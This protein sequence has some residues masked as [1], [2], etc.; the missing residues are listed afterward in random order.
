MCR[1]ARCTLQA[2]RL[3]AGSR[4]SVRP[5]AAPLCIRSLLRWQRQFENVCFVS[6]IFSKTKHLA[7]QVFVSHR[8]CLR[9]LS[10]M[11]S[12]F[13]SFFVGYSMESARQP[14]NVSWS[15]VLCCPEQFQ[16]ERKRSPCYAVANSLVRSK[17]LIG[18]AT[19]AQVH[20]TMSSSG[21]SIEQAFRK[22][23]RSEGAQRHQMARRSLLK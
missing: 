17:R 9:G 14:S 20:M 5:H 16:R 6:Q 11:S 19:Y 10:R 23:T 13:F 12:F 4:L 18:V 1:G 22:V 3:R 2:L 7:L 21:E 8:V 15:R